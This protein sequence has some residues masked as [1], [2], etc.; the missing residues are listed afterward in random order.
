MERDERGDGESP[1]VK[2]ERRKRGDS[3]GKNKLKA[4]TGKEFV[5]L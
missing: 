3:E 1:T 2:M 5:Y 4:S